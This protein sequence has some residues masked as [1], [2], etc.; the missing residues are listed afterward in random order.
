MLMQLQETL[1]IYN[2]KIF[3]K[4][5]NISKKQRYQ[6]SAL[7]A[8]NRQKSNDDVTS[9]LFTVACNISTPTYLEHQVVYYKVLK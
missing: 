6:F 1:D 5:M 9:L 8:E 3:F 4:N 2:S 7:L